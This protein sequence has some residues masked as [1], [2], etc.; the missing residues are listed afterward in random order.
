[1]KKVFEETIVGKLL[2]QKLP[3]VMNTIGNVMPNQEVLEVVEQLIQ[4]DQSL[5]NEEKKE[6]LYILRE[7]ELELFRLELEDRVH[8]RHREKKKIK[9]G[10]TDWLMIASGIT[11]LSSFFMIIFAVIF[12]PIENNTL[13]HQLMGLIEGI[14]LTIFAYYFGASKVPVR[15]SN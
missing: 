5:S 13:F 2:R 12:L 4:R 15:S 1:M 8:A 9:N 3:Q 6:F 10:V 14:A 7:Y 11:A